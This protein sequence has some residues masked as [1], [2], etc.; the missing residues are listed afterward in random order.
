MN[1]ALTRMMQAPGASY[2]FIADRL[3]KSEIT[4][5]EK[6]ENG[7]GA[8]VQTKSGKLA[9]YKDYSGQLHVMSPVCR[10]LKCI[11]DWNPA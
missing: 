5:A 7:Q 8:L 9:V 10:H 3:S 4:E 11:V 6:L 1:T 2:H